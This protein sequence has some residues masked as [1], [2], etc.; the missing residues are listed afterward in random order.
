MVK[1]GCPDNYIWYN[2][3]KSV[4][5]DVGRALA[6]PYNEVDRISKM[7]PTELGITIDKALNK[8]PELARIYEEEENVEIIVDMA[9]RL[10]GMP[11]HASTH[12]AGVVICQKPVMEYVPLSINDGCNNYTIYNDN[13]WKNLVILK[14]TS[15]G[16][17]LL[18]LYRMQ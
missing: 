2:G 18:Q 4:I 14:W 15:L 16:L 11:R 3:S 9:K 17:E 7:I 12:A 5:K 6:I 1:I 13:I 10:E 8:N